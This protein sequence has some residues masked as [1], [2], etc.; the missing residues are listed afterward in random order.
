[1]PLCWRCLPW[2]WLPWRCMPWDFTLCRWCIRQ[3][4][5][6]VRRRLLSTCRWEIGR[7]VLPR[8]WQGRTLRCWLRGVF[9]N[10]R[11]RSRCCLA[12][13]GHW[14]TIT[15][16]CDCCQCQQHLSKPVCLMPCHQLGLPGKRPARSEPR[17]HIQ[18]RQH[19]AHLLW[20]CRVQSLPG[21]KPWWAGSVCRLIF[22][23]QHS[24][25]PC[26]EPLSKSTI[27]V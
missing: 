9:P 18:H 21:R 19:Q 12:W 22:E 6:C 14:N 5:F 3:R 10:C 24:G 17:P 16:P 8:G 4:R 27:M 1:M 2:A 26:R 13:A 15:G 11:H 7:A 23:T 25:G 20:K